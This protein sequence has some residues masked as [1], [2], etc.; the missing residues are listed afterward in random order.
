M[1]ITVHNID[2]VT[3]YINPEQIVVLHPTNE[4]GNKGKPNELMVG[5]VH[6]V[7]GLA[8]GKRVSVVETC[9][10]VSRMMEDAK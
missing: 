5:G 10:V 3:I 2:G 6:C 1:L 8:D 7:V 4:G 9:G